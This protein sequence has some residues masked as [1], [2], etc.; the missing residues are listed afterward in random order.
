MRQIRAMVLVVLLVLIVGAT[1]SVALAATKSVG[2][3][4]SGSKFHFTPATVT[5]KKG[6]SVR[7]SWSGSVPHNVKGSG[8]NSKT[9]AKVTFTRKFSKAGR[10][11]VVCTIHQALGQKMT[12]VVR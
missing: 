5:I 8:F 10:F 4:K 7:W 11:A 12:V 2:V 3:K 9:G 6:D 1:A